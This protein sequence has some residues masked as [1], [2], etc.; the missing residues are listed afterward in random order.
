MGTDGMLAAVVRPGEHDGAA[1]M[2]RETECT[3]RTLEVQLSA[4][5]DRSEVGRLNRA[6]ANVEV[7]LSAPTMAILH[8]ARLAYAETDGAFDV[9]CLPQIDL[10][11][12]AAQRGIAPADA[13]LAAARAASNWSQV[14]LTETGAVKQQAGVQLDLGGIAKGYAIDRAVE[15]L[16]R[17]GLPGGLVNLGGDLRC[18]GHTPAG[19]LW[20]IDL[21]HPFGEGKLGTITATDVAVC[22]SGDYR[23]YVEVDGRRRSHILDPRTGQPAEA[24]ASATV[25]AP[26]AMTADIWATALSVLGAEGLDMLPDEVDALIVVGD[27]SHHHLLMTDGFGRR[28]RSLVGREASGEGSLPPTPGARSSCWSRAG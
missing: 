25:M 20:T 23:R 3:L 1:D 18:F 11:R 15:V 16:K 17:Q 26:D 21:Q 12:Q 2:L 13:E 19:G 27:E 22:T 8:A 6:A 9:T 24:A 10:W 4:W 28:F 7:P 14:R 5:L